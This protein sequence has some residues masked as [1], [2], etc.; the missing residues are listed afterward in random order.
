MNNTSLDFAIRFSTT[1][2]PALVTWG[3]GRHQV[4]KGELGLLTRLK[5]EA[6]AEGLP[7]LEA[8]LA[9]LKKLGY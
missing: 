4:E 5:H 6:L 2:N 3:V 7:R 1:K 9:A 8:E